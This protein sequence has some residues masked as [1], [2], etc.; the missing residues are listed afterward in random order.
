MARLG[1]EEVQQF[2]KEGWLVGR[3][4]V[5]A[6]LLARLNRQLADWVEESRSRIGNYGETLAGTHRFDL[7][8]GH[9]ADRPRLR[10][11]NNPVE[12]SDIFREA[13]F[14]SAI[15][16]MAA[17]VISPDIKFLHSKVNLKLPGTD[18]RVGF[19]SDFAYVPHTN[20]DVVTT[21]LMLTDM[22]VDNGCLTVVPGSHLEAPRSLW[23]GD[24]FAG[25]VAPDAA[26]ECVQRAVPVTGRAGSVV[27]MHAKTLHG[28]DP[29][30]SGQAR[31]LYIGIYSAADAMP[32]S[33]NSLPNRDEGRMVRGQPTRTARLGG[34]P[35]EL[36]AAFRSTSFFEVQGQ[37]SV[38]ANANH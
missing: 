21:L 23:R 22:T 36:P 4:A 2:K 38:Y 31:G 37:Q 28:S 35:V 14:D 6:D 3:D 26:A 34:G 9:S 15:A 10:R 16:D 1:A 19:H 24:V 29:N 33:P 13:T 20:E 5:S 11:V 18:T 7:E 30:R 17:E 25:E 12:V 27:L 32:I 8:K